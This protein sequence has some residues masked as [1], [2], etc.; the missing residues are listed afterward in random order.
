[1]PGLCSSVGISEVCCPPSLVD[2]S[3]STGMLRQCMHV[4]R[5]WRRGV[6]PVLYL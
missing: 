2:Q 1:V 3:P 4:S 5:E 6:G